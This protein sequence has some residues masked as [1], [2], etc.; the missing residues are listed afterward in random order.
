MMDVKL[1]RIL[2]DAFASNLLGFPLDASILADAVYA[3]STTMDGRHFGE[4]FVR[5]K[6]LA[7]RGIVEKQPTPAPGADTKNSSS[8]GWNEVAKKGSGSSAAAVS[9]DEATIPGGQ[10]KVVPARKKGKK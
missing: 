8:G 1:T 5:R 7:D 10:F 3:N 6:K 9:K 2:V 4:E